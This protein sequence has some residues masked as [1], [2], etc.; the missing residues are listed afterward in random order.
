M[1]EKPKTTN[2]ALEGVE[3]EILTSSVK[4]AP[5]QIET[6]AGVEANKA[7]AEHY[8]ENVVLGGMM[9]ANQDP[10]TPLGFQHP[11]VQEE[12]DEAHP[13]GQHT[14]E[15]VA[16]LEADYKLDVNPDDV[17]AEAEAELHTSDEAAKSGTIVQ[18]G[19]R[20]VPFGAEEQAELPAEDDEQHSE[21]QLVLR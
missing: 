12:L 20:M 8:E 21:K 9:R 18:H 16:G 2:P 15:E 5:H 4:I 19:D 3:D 7:M 14:D 13:N 11:D 6:P 17:P 10:S 1:S